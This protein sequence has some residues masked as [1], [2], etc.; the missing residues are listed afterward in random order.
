MGTKPQSS[1]GAQGSDRAGWPIAH[2]RLST[3]DGHAPHWLGHAVIAKRVRWLMHELGI[4]GEAPQRKPRTTDSDH[5]FPRYPNLVEGREVTHPDRVWAGDI[6]H[7]GLRNTFTCILFIMHSFT[8][9][10]QGWHLS[11]SLEQ[12]LT[13]TALR[14][15][16]ERRIPEIH[17]SDQGCNMPRRPTSRCW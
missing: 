5:T 3:A 4:T 6:A 10:I 14:R 15:P 1:A 2:V 16:L 8:Q 9:R 13:T 7:I 11:Q 17:R 12:E